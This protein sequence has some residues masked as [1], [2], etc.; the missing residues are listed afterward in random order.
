MPPQ[1]TKQQNKSLHKYLGMVALELA[2][3]GQTMQDVVK[4]ISLVEITPTTQSIKEV[5]WKPIQE[6]TLGKVSTTEL[7]TAE[8][9]KVYEVMSMFLSKEFEISL[10]FPSQENSPNYIQ[11]YER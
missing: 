4:K 8:I 1:R 10:P 11:S 9:N 6:A 7:T 3:Q 5:L 2:N